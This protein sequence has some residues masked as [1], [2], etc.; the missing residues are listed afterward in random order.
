M[1][2]YQQ[3]KRMGASWSRGVSAQPPGKYMEMMER[4]EENTE[5]FY[6]DPFKF[7]HYIYSTELPDPEDPFKDI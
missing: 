4:A 1:R 5:E 3:R 7:L 6:E 2:I